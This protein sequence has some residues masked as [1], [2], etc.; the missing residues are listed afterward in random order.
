MDVKK[1]INYLQV[2]QID[3]YVFVGQSPDRPPRIFGGQV[4][5]QCLNAA[6]RTVTEDRLAHSLHAYFLRP[7]NPKKQILFEVDPIRDGGSFTTRRIIAKQDGIPIFNMSASFHIMEE[8][9]SHQSSMPDVPAPE[10]LETD[11]DYWAR[12][13]ERYP[14]GA[15]PPDHFPIERRNVNRRDYL[16]PKP[17]KPHQQ[18]WFRVTE[19]LDD[20]PRLHQVLLAYI[21]DYGLLGTAMYP[22]PMTWAM[23]NVQAASLDHGLWFHRPFRVDDFFLV[24][25]DSPSASGNRGFSR[26]TFYTRDGVLIASSVQES[27][28]RIRSKD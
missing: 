1:L 18:C 19:E 9:H 23:K 24:E 3:K 25:L 10:T 20:D 21:S 15:R 28:A 11:A 2:E 26:G 17:M 7:G 12:N 4:L 14:E 5:A 27:L 22:H 6:S 13:A 8:G 16:N